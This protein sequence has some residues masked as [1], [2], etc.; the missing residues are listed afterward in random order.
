M[1]RSVDA[2]F[3]SLQIRGSVLRRLRD[4]EP[5][6]R[7]LLSGSEASP[8]RISHSGGGSC[9]AAPYSKPYVLCFATDAASEVI[10]FSKGNVKEGVV[11]SPP[12][13]GALR[14]PIYLPSP[15]KRFPSIPS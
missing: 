15:L 1:W 7:S 5:I 9:F 8:S 14:S 2:S 11:D 13:R 4:E 6:S 12:S 10:D 3:L